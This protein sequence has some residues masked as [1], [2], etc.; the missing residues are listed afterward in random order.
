MNFTKY[1]IF[2]GLLIF[3]CIPIFTEIWLPTRNAETYT[4]RYA[5]SKVLLAQFFSEITGG[6]WEDELSKQAI[7][8]YQLPLAE[9]LN[10]F[11]LILMNCNLDTSRSFLFSEMLGEDAV[12]LKKYLINLKSGIEFKKLNSTQQLNVT[13]WIEELNNQNRSWQAQLVRRNRR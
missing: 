13:Q 3:L 1:R 10:F 2:L 11:A 5:V 4:V 7:L 8:I 6:Y 9:R 12:N